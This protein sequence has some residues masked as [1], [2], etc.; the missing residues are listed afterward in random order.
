[1]GILSRFGN[2]VLASR[3]R[4][5]ISVLVFGFLPLLGWVS[6]VILALVTLRKGALEGL[7][8]LVWVLIPTSIFQFAL[9]YTHLAWFSFL[10]GPVFIWAMA[11]VLRRF[12]SWTMVLELT[13][14]YGLLI[15]L[16]VHL[17]VP[18]IAGWWAHYYE[19]ALSGISQTAASSSSG[20]AQ[21][22]QNV[23]GMLEQPDIVAFITKL[24]TGT[25]AIMTLLFSLVNLA[26]GRFWQAL[27]FNPRGLRPE[28][29][30][31]RLGY[32]A[33]GV[34]LVLGALAYGQFPLAWDLLP[35]MIGVFVAASLSVLHALLG[36]TKLALAWLILVYVL[37]VVLSPY[38]VLAIIL[39]GIVDSFVNLR[40]RFK[41]AALK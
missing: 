34:L 2:Y 41:P 4:A 18:D 35:I 40:E 3:A 27:L 31:V 26:L 29:T 30:N 21:T 36:K 9:G 5:I 25:V 28:L 8:V 20:D 10:G 23:A 13:A 38:S 16:G 17:L 1:M 15:V 7:W 6:S 11:L 37:L 19:S 39:V 22:A 32:I 24:A 14:L 12:A 33:S